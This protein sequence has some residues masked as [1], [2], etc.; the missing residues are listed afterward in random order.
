MASSTEGSQPEQQTTLLHVVSPSPEVPERL[1][2]PVVLNSTTIGDLK[3]KIRDAVPSKPAPER[4]RL[5]YR[6]K[7]LLQDELTL[8]AVFKEEAARAPSFT[9]MKSS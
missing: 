7:P 1:K 8:S 4:Q 3:A 5:I 2:I 6:A 9:R